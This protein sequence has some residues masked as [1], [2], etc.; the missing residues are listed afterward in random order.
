[1]I[2]NRMKGE[3]QFF[4]K[5]NGEL[6]PLLDGAVS[7]NLIVDQFFE[8][9]GSGVNGGS[10]S[11]ISFSPSTASLQSSANRWFIVGTGTTPPQPTDTGLENQ[12][13]STGTV[14]DHTHSYSYDEQTD[15]LIFTTVSTRSFSLGGVVGNISEVGVEFYGLTPWDS[16][17]LQ[18]RALI[19]DSQGDPTTI[20]LGEDDQLVVV[21]TL[22]RVCNRSFTGTVNDIGYE[23]KLVGYTSA[24]NN[25]GQGTLNAISPTTNSRVTDQDWAFPAFNGN[26][27]PNTTSVSLSTVSVQNSNTKHSRVRLRLPLA[28]GNYVEGLKGAYFGNLNLQLKFDQPIMKT[29]Q[30]ILDIEFFTSFE[31]MA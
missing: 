20:S 13:A 16:R 21:Y 30:D 7:R 23:G 2:K 8:C 14:I 18:S 31:N 17:S 24:G 4:N 28:V 1:M 6:I 29:N 10:N 9:L 25:I 26:T 3:F 19:K 11:Y 15:A 5:R 27:F 12:L 22:T